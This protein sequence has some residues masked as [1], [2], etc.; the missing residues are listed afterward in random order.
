MLVHQA[1]LNHSAVWCRFLRCHHRISPLL[2][3]LS[4]K[5]AASSWDK[6]ADVVKIPSFLSVNADWSIAHRR[7]TM[8]GPM[9][10][11]EREVK[12]PDRS[13][14]GTSHEIENRTMESGWR[15]QKWHE[16]GI[17]EK[18]KLSKKLSNK[19]THNW[20]KLF[21]KYGNLGIK[22]HR[23]HELIKLA[24]LWRKNTSRFDRRQSLKQ[25]RIHGTRC[26]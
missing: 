3:A 18:N 22:D 8:I 21:S 14:I 26:A 12:F 13:V 15:C 17:Q 25:G 6:N 5:N 10:P 16:M 9:A 1:V 24:F 20:W 7:L 11:S 19:H 4:S 23:A 2:L